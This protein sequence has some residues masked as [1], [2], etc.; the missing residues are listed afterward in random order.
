[1]SERT[2]LKIDVNPSAQKTREPVSEKKQLKKIITGS[3]VTKKKSLGKKFWETFFG[4]GENFSSVS[5]YVIHDVIVPAIKDLVADTVKG[6]IEMMLFGDTKGSRTRRDGNRSFVNYGGVNTSRDRDRN[7]FTQTNRRARHNFDDIVLES[8]G[9]AEEVL[10]VLVELI[11]S[12][13]RQATVA[14][15]YNLVGVSANF[16]DDKWGWTDLSQASVVRARSG[17]YLLSL[18]KTVLLD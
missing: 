3:V 1:M 14:D 12:D 8:R 16:T 5:Q 9:E 13:Y 18:P 17:G 11:D 4:E 6:G 10:S 7:R 2:P 15:L